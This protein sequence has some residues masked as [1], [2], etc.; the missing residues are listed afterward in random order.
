MFSLLLFPIYMLATQFWLLVSSI[1]LFMF[2]QGLECKLIK[3]LYSLKQASKAWFSK[4]SN[5]LLFL[6]FVASKFD[7]SLFTKDT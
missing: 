6:G 2:P 3:T 4:L 1:V 5:C 7:T